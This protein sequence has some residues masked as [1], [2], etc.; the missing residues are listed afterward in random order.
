MTEKLDIE[1]IKEKIMVK[2]QPS[3]WARVLRG[4]IYSKDFDNIIVELAK[5]AKD[6]KRFTPTMKNWFRAFEECPYTDI[7]VVIIGQDPYPGVGHADGISFSLSQTDDMQPSLKY[8]LN[9]VNRTVY[10]NEQ[11]STDKDLTRWANQGV[12]MFNTAL[13]TNVGK[14]GQHYL[15]WKPFAAYLF[16]WLTWHCPGL[17]YVYLGKKAEEWADCVNDNNYKFFVSH[18]AAASYTGLKEWDC[19]NVFNEIKDILKK[20]NNFDIEW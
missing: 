7:K 9:A 16:D 4:F 12:L 14:I 17:I 15:I 2:L 3:G 5:Q 1:E 11:I 13:T 6:G 10:D 18:P 20:N 19:K 8:L